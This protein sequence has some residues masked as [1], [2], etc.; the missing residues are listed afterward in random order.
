MKINDKSIIHLA[1]NFEHVDKQGFLYKKGEINRSLQR[2]WF[3]LTGNLLF[4]FEK[5]YSR[6]PI[7]VVVLEGYV[8][9]RDP[10]NTY[11]FLLCFA[12]ENTRTWTFSAENREDMESWM[13]ALARSSYDYMRDLANDLDRQIKELR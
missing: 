4:Y 5:Q 11:G 3:V 2:R 7:G 12:G 8:V 9:S 1:N 6:E 13:Q 10:N